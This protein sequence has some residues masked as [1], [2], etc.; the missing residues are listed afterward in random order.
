[1]LFCFV[2]RHSDQHSCH[3]TSA[4]ARGLGP[5][6]V[7]GTIVSSR[8][9]LFI[10]V[11]P[12]RTACLCAELSRAISR[13][14]VLLT[15]RVS[16]QTRDRR[17]FAEACCWY[18][19]EESRRWVPPRGI[20]RPQQPGCFAQGSGE[21]DSVHS[22]AALSRLTKRREGFEGAALQQPRPSPPRPKQP[23]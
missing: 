12:Q 16:G 4:R 19:R 11:K 17:R 15:Y 2:Y 6:A 10:H 22:W 5:L 20:R 3:W 1:M 13:L 9:K 14:F 18:T 21:T 7:G 8:L 23:A